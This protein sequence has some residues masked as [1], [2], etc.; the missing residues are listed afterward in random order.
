MAPSQDSAAKRGRS[1]SV[2]EI[3]RFVLEEESGVVYQDGT[4]SKD[5][6][7]KIVSTIEQKTNRRAGAPGRRGRLQDA[8]EQAAF[9]TVFKTAAPGDREKVLSSAWRMALV[10]ARARAHSPGLIRRPLCAPP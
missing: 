9:K 10:S 2:C 4:A 3:C 6:T 5:D 8:Q 7:S 1:L